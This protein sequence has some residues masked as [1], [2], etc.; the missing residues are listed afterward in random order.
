MATIK[1]RPDAETEWTEI[2]TL[3]GAT[4]AAGADGLTAYEQAVAGG[5]ND[6]E[7]TFMADLAAVEGLAAELAAI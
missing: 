2:V 1:L 3:R 5:Y 4:G 6:D 7:A